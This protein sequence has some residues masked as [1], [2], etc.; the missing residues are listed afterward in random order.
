MIKHPDNK[1]KVK[2]ISPVRNG[3]TDSGWR[4]WTRWSAREAGSCRADPI[5]LENG[6]GRSRN[7][8][9]TRGPIQIYKNMLVDILQCPDREFYASMVYNSLGQAIKRR[10]HRT[11]VCSTSHA[12]IVRQSRD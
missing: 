4:S 3:R 7:Y 5:L 9:R 2:Q 11:L 10:P 6:R 1:Q 12:R 8:A